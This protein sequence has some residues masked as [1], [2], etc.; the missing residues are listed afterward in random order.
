MKQ[1]VFALIDCNNFFVSCERLFRPDLEGK[2]VVVLSS[3]DGCVVARSNE[4]KALGVPMGAPAFKYRLLFT[5][6]GIVQFS[7]NFELYSDI[8]RRITQVL[9]SVT[10]RI[11]IY[12]VDESFLDLSSLPIS[13]YDEWAQTVRELLFKWVGVPVS[14]GIAPTKTLAKLA[15]EHAKKVP[16]LRGVLSFIDK[17]DSFK[18]DYLSKTPVQAVWG[19][20][21][22]TA[23][24]LRTEGIGS[25]FDLAKAPARRSQQLLGIHGRQMVA[26]LGG[27][28]C[29][30][31]TLEG[32]LPQTISATRTFGQDTNEFT[33]LEAAIASFVGTSTFKL[34]RSNQLAT[35]A[36]FFLTTNRNK[37]G[38][39]TWSRELKLDTPSSDPGHLM[40]L[41]NKELRTVYS[42][43]H[44]YHRAGVWLGGFTPADQFQT[45]LLDMAG[46]L[47]HSRSKSKMS[48]VDGLNHRYGRGTIR[49]AAEDLANSWRPYPKLRSPHYTSDW[50]DLPAVRT[51]PI[52]S[53]GSTL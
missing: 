33:V 12:S 24:K 5:Q 45:D 43:V 6:Q 48:A 13:D 16:E 7:A 42:P 23:P 3:G 14:I 52:N 32:K 17:P 34:R 8:S 35:R 10:P 9:T 47:V 46:P 19:V 27:I 36:G 39:T 15:S 31:L 51:Y 44:S 30:P 11:E 29:Y 37:P 18:N 40:Q 41:L 49:L 26:E 50:N 4:A 53:A 28:S 20:G 21:W 22:R 2:P 38:Y 25:A 1:P